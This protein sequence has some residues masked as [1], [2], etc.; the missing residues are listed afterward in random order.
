MELTVRALAETRHAFDGVAPTYDGLNA[1]NPIL[2][3]LRARTMAALCSRLP[4]GARLLDLG[5]GP[6]ED[7]ESLARLGYR[8]T[9]ID[10]SSAMA[11]RAR[12]RVERAGLAARV[13]IHHLGIQELEQLD[14]PAFDGAYSNL[15]PL[16][17]VPDLGAAAGTLAAR[18]RP[19]GVLV[20]SVIGR[21]CPWEIA[22][23]AAAADWRRIRVRFSNAFVPVPLEGGTVWTRY[24]RPTE[25][26]ARFHPAG[27]RTRSLEALA[28]CTP[29]P[30]LQG[31]H[32][33]HPR[34]MRRLDRIERAIARWPLVRQTGDHFLIVLERV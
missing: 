30:Y 2:Q 24:Y 5:C 11:Q 19:G 14:G 17:C 28:V 32:G 26:E 10:W 31:F 3:G 8:I 12:D 18:L 23:Y 20:A 13:E 34:L 4:A 7:A 25:F 16:N 33:R 1:A 27:F 6:G 21:I 29:P 22:R 9:A 15:G